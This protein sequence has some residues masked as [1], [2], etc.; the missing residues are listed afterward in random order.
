MVQASHPPPV[1]LEDDDTLPE[2]VEVAVLEALASPPPLSELS[3]DRL[4]SPPNPPVA[5]ADEDIFPEPP[6]V[7]PLT[8]FA[9]PPSPPPQGRSQRLETAYSAIGAQVK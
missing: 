6:E 8:A 5:S 3:T 7:A 4:P 2:P 1:A 9:D